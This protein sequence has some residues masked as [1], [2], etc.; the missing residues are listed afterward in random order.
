MNDQEQH[1]AALLRQRDRRSIELLYDLYG[2]ALFGIA[3]RIVRSRQ[4]AEDVVQDVFVKVWKN[5]SHY[6]PSKGRLFTWLLNITRNTAIDQT[7]TA[8]Y[9]R[10]K[11]MH[12]LDGVDLVTGHLSVQPKPEYIGLRDLV[13]GLD[14]KYKEVIDLIYFQ[15]FTQQEVTQELDLPLG[16]VKSRTR[17]AIRE[18]RKFFESKRVGLMIM[19]AIFLN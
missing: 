7:R 8:S 5:G 1:I 10:Q 4:V 15:G 18:L 12:G 14:H 3:L 11:N 13:D 17:I 6:H 19:L 2:P 16:T 9:R